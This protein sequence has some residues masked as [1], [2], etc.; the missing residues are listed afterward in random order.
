MVT[1]PTYVFWH[2]LSL[3]V[4]SSSGWR[5]LLLPALFFAVQEVGHNFRL[6]A[7]MLV[8][9][10]FALHER[11]RRRSA[12]WLHRLELVS[13]LHWVTLVRP[14]ASSSR[15]RH[16]NTKLTDA[17]PFSRPLPSPLTLPTASLE[18]LHHL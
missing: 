13:S 11:L 15:K 5:R 10:G 8:H 3:E 17:S 18:R 9:E 1:P 14:P 12:R 7:L 16:V 6:L 2:A 4:A